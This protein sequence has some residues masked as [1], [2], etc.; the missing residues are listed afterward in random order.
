MPTTV[1]AVAQL[2]GAIAAAQRWWATPGNFLEVLAL[3]W[4]Q[5]LVGLPDHFEGGFTS[6]GATANLVCLAAARQ[7][8]GETRGF[9]PSLDGLHRFVEPRIYASTEVHHVVHRAC[10]VLGFGRRAL[11]TISVDAK[12]TPDLSA[13]ERA[14]DEDLAAGRTP[15]A[16]VASAGDAEHRRRG[17]PIGTPMREI[18]RGLRRA[19]RGRCVR[20]LRRPRSARRASV[21]GPREDRLVRRRPA[22]VDGGSRGVRGGVRARRRP[23]RARAHPRTGCLLGDGADPHGRPRARP[24]TSAARGTPTIPSTSRRRHAVSRCGP[25]SRR[26]GRQACAR[27]SSAI[28]TVRAASLRA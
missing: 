5:R 17:R 23:P 20:R 9:D 8:A 22:Q 27:A 2:A 24:S 18:A 26:W 6:G 14:L 10:G 19:A 25:R 12:R 21:R 7:H 13:L 28:T 3:R 1:P 15:V 4:L 11:R 16:V